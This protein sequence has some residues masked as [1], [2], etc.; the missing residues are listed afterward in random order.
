MHHDDN[1]FKQCSKCGY[2]WGAR[3]ELL[4]DPDITILGYQVNT[5]DLLGGLIL[6]NHGCDTT[7]AL[8]VQALRDLYSGPVYPTLKIGETG[9]PGHCL[10]EYELRSCTNTCEGAYAREIL[11]IVKQWPKN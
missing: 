6:F 5:T 11:Q 1:C 9:C 10:D 3:S 4:G 8:K 2:V 7:L